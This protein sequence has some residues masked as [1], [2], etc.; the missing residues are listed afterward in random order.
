MKKMMGGAIALI[1]GVPG[2]AIFFPALAGLLA[3]ILPVILI[4]GGSL[5]MYLGYEDYK[6]AGAETAEAPANTV[7]KESVETDQA[8]P[9]PVEPNTP[10]DRE[11]GQDTPNEASTLVGNTD[12]LVF[13]L[14]DCKFSHSKK[15]TQHFISKE[16]AIGQGYKP[17]KICNP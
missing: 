14:S 1:I 17:C 10:A 15:C 3:G 4:L 16:E 8:D 5:A 6:A 9:L 7:P 11:N 12:S 2:F 13:H